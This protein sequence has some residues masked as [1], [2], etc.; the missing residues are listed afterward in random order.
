MTGLQMAKVIVDWEARRDNQGRIK[1]YRLP[2]ND[3]GATAEFPYEYAGINGRYDKE[4]LRTIVELV[5]AGDHAVAECYAAS[6]IE[7]NTSA[8]A[9]WTTNHAIEF[10]M[11]DCIF[12]RGETGASKILQIAVGATVDGK[13]GKL[14]KARVAELANKPFALLARIRAGRQT[15]ENMVAPNRPNLRQGLENRWDNATEYACRMLAL[16]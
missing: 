11:R 10:A 14:T 12:N 8:A 15:Y 2:T 3:G 9:K 4:A 7:T 1:L 13:I 6:Y 16:L 5:Q